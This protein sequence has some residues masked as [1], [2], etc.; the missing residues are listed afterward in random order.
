[1]VSRRSFLLAGGA[2]ALATG[3]GSAVASRRFVSAA[4]DTQGEHFVAAFDEIGELRYRTPIGFRGHEVVIAPDRKTATVVARRPRTSLVQIR[5]DDGAIIGRAEA[6]AG[7]HF[8]GHGVYTGDG[9]LL[10][11]TEN[12]FERTRGVVTVRDASNLR[13]VEEFDSHGVGPHEMRWLSDGHTLAVANGGIATHPRTGRAKL[14]LDSMRPNLAYI[15]VRSG[16]LIGRVDPDYRYNSVRHLDVLSNDA[17]VVGMQQEDG[18]ATDQLLIAVDGARANLP[19]L[20][21]SPVNLRELNQYI[22]SV[23]ADRETGNVV[24]TCP[25]GNRV[26]FWDGAGAAFSRSL[27]IADA[28]GVCVDEVSREFVVTTGRGMIYRF[29]C[30]TFKQSIGSPARVPKLS[31]DNHLAAA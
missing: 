24:A 6:A 15:D 30:T 13:V 3:C 20:P 22:A 10:F 5:L 9:A 7:R 27:R 14:N 16:E 2:A 17:V 23:C 12:D 4:T 25:R 21:M 26:V 11:T 31:W 18:S 28:A 29:D 1:M 19:S 8:Y